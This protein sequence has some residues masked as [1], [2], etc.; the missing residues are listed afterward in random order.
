[1][2]EVQHLHCER[3][4]LTAHRDVLEAF[5]PDAVIDCRALTRTDAELALAA[6]P[7]VKR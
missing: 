4:A 1:M 2:P 5:G 6:L 7:E 3:A